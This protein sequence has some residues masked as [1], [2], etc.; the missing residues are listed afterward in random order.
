M[1]EIKVNLENL[2][3]NERKQLLALIEK[4]NKKPKRFKPESGQIFWYINLRNETKSYEWGWGSFYQGCYNSNNCF[5]NEEEAK[6]EAEKRKVI[7]ELENFVLENNDEIDWRNDSQKK[8][9]LFYDSV[10][11]ALQSDW[12]QRFQQQGAIYF[13][14]RELCKQAI[15]KVGKDRIKKY[16]FGVEE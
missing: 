13:S 2:K 14:S 1:N 5:A 7:A 11:N 16:L 4:A 6:F 10:V 15:E 12:Y 9:C 8:Y 3:D